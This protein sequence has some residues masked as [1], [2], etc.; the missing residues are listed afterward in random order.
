MQSN[1]VLDATAAEATRYV[2]EMSTVSL[3]GKF[4]GIVD[5]AAAVDSKQVEYLKGWL[6]NSI[7]ETIN[8]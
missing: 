7:L 5:A 6:T 2:T 3:Q 4:V 8:I 1:R